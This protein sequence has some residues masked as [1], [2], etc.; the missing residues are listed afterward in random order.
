MI[1]ITKTT[2]AALVPALAP[3][4]NKYSRGVCELVVGSETFPGA[5]VLAVMAASRMGAGYV[6]AYASSQT[7]HA[8]HIV[9]PSAVVVPFDDYVQDFHAQDGRNPQAVVVGCGLTHEDDDSRRTLDV[10]AYTAAPVLVDGGGLAAIVTAEGMECMR[11]RFIEGYPTVITPHGGEAFRTIHS[12][13]A[14]GI[15]E[16][17]NLDMG[18]LSPASMCLMLAR[19]FG[20]VCVLKGPDTFIA[21][22]NEEEGDEEGAGE[23]LI[24]REGTPALAKAG[25]GDV[26]AGTIG[27]LMAQGMDAKDACTLG[28][29]VHA[30]AGVLASEALGEFCVT[31]EDVVSHLP[32]A[33]REL[34]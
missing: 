17:A 19:T 30:R 22:G 26:L 5:G 32:A 33:V 3:D 20:V 6:K 11:N 10:L 12:L 34:A 25:T 28:T 18:S 4:A 9:Q 23:V 27:A 24:M 1:D 16:F 2:V 14:N 8:L 31:A 21:D 15:E 13:A 7:A 29:F